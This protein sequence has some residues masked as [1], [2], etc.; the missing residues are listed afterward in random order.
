MKRR[1]SILHTPLFYYCFSLGFL[2]SLLISIWMY[3]SDDQKIILDFSHT[4]NDYAS[5]IKEDVAENIAILHSFRGFLEAQNNVTR[6]EFKTYATAILSNYTI[7][8]A[9]G[10]IPRIKD[11]ERILIETQVQSEGFPDFQITQQHPLGRLVRAADA[12]EYY[13]IFYIEP[14]EGN[15]DALGFDLSSDAT[16]NKGIVEARD[17][18]ESLTTGRVKLVQEKNTGTW[19]E[20]F[21]V[22]LY[23]GHPSTLDE[24]REMFR[25][26]IS[27]VIRMQDIMTSL[28][29]FHTVEGM[30]NLTLKEQCPGIPPDILYETDIP[31]N[32]LLPRYQYGVQVELDTKHQWLLQA[33]PTK[34]Y[35][36]SKRSSTPYAVLL[37]GSLISFLFAYYLAHIACEK[38][39]V[40]EK[41]GQRTLALKEQ[42]DALKASNLELKT[43]ISERNRLQQQYAEV[44]DYEQRRLGQELHDSLGQQIAVAAMLT[45][46]VQRHF[47]QVEGSACPQLDLLEKAIGRSQAQVRALSKGLLPVEVDP[48]GIK[49]AFGALVAS[50]GGMNEYEVRLECDEEIGVPDPAIATQLYRIAQEAIRN[51]LEH[52]EVSKVVIRL[53]QTEERL[54][55]SIEDDG[56][57]LDPNQTASIGSGLSIMKYRAELIGAEIKFNSIAGKGT[58]VICQLSV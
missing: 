8:K 29:S 41:V 6:S 52:G 47:K 26:I 57:G 39:W 25:G 53:H 12:A 20:L 3:T 56:R 48:A 42:T 24:R 40:E 27:G 34:T 51:A 10:W 16:R 46:Y 11:E 7:M 38:V 2:I 19:A 13:P 37:I 30:I 15:S 28:T 58:A 35:I 33:I 43:A 32:E 4:V 23:K 5:T 17:S 9:V 36:R 50:V 54:T 55:L 31:Q 21:L 14:M 1:T 18:G 45:Q 49:D 22:P 44:T